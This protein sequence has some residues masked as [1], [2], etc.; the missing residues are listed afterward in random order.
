MTTPAPVPPPVELPADVAVYVEVLHLLAER[1]QQLDTYRK[2]SEAVLKNALGDAEVGLIA[3]R[4]VVFWRHIAGGERLDKKRLCTEHPEVVPLLKAYTVRGAPSRR[5]T[6]A[7][8]AAAVPA[9][10]GGGP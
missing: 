3:G 6:L 10:S 2:V 1:Q 5:F 9:P 7:Q 4:P 8:A